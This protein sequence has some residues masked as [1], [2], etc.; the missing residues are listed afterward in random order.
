[1]VHSSV[2][3]C[4]IESIEVMPM[5]SKSIPI[6][7]LK[8]VQSMSSLADNTNVIEFVFELAAT[9]SITNAGDTA[10]S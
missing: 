2:E 4:V 5:A 6:D 1:M 8:V 3:V 10:N 9:D 7:A